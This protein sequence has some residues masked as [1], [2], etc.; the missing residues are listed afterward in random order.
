VQFRSALVRTAHNTTSTIF[1][2]WNVE[3]AVRDI[4]LSLAIFLLSP[5]ALRYPFAGV[6]LWA[7]LSLM[8]PHRLT[9]GFAQDFPFNLVVAILTLLGC[10]FSSER[11][12]FKADA[13]LMLV[14][15]FSIWITLTTLV[16][17]VPEVTTPLWERDIKTMLLLFMVMALIV[18][19][20]KIHGLIW[21]MV[22]SL[23]YYGLKG[24][25][26]TIATGGNYKVFGPAK[27]MIED[28][29]GLALAL[30]ITIPLMNYLRLY[31][32][33]RLLRLGL[34]AAMPIS[35]ASII[36]SYS[37][38]GFIAMAAMLAFFLMKGR[39]KFATAILAMCAVLTALAFM[40]DKYT[41]RLSTINDY[42]EDSSM[43]GRFDAWRVA[44]ETASDN[45]FGAGFDGPRQAV[46]WQHYLPDAVPRASHSIYF[47]VLGEHGFL[48]L[49]LYLAIC[50][51]AWR[52]LS[53]VLAL[54]RDRHDDLGWA[55]DLARSLQVSML[56]FLVGGAALPMAYYDGFL[57][58]I[59]CSSC[60]VRI[61][62][63]ALTDAAPQR[64]EMRPTHL[65]Q[66]MHIP[67]RR[68]ARI[69][70]IG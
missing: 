69:E 70:P 46:V 35:L 36:G 18:D 68:L 3:D 13:L 49:F 51:V 21:I 16:A 29:N 56:G 11:L 27:S 57:L 58:L 17:P 15:A 34:L 26:F 20:T 53:R 7:W 33:H 65:P 41:E 50:I 67:K 39:A 48:G 64:N 22:I 32:Q 62:G 5:I 28:N 47:M 43:Q 10:L 37:R 8:N 61:V 38:G 12:K 63:E 59:A 31:T 55:N 1:V 14:A 54:T 52:N 40:P 2:V 24:G 19:R 6:Y 23:G 25:A 9:Y 45:F 60:L 30:I 66:Y 44:F 4:A 42:R